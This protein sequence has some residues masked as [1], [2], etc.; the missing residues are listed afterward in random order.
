VTFLLTFPKDKIS[1]IS[2]HVNIILDEQTKKKIIFHCME[3]LSK[4]VVYWLYVVE[5]PALKGYISCCENL[6]A[7]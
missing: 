3:I 6:N 4:V 1:T 5:T 2:L 7:F